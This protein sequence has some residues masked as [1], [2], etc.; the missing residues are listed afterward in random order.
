[1]VHE[2]T[3]GRRM[4]AKDMCEE[5]LVIL[6]NLAAASEDLS[7]STYDKVPVIGQ[8]ETCAC[9]DVHIVCEAGEVFHIISI[10]PIRPRKLRKMVMTCSHGV[11]FAH[12]CLQCEGPREALT[13]RVFDKIRVHH[14]K[15]PIAPPIIRGPDAKL[16]KRRSLKKIAAP[17]PVV[18][19]EKFQ[20]SLSVTRGSKHE[21]VGTL[22]N[23][24]LVR[25]W[26]NGYADGSGHWEFSNPSVDEL[27]GMF[28]GPGFEG[29]RIHQDFNGIRVHQGN[30][31]DHEHDPRNNADDAFKSFMS[32]SDAAWS[33]L[34]VSLAVG[35]VL[36]VEEQKGF[37]QARISRALRDIN[38]GLRDVVA[39]VH[40]AVKEK[41]ED[42]RCKEHNLFNCWECFDFKVAEG[43]ERWRT[44]AREMTS[45]WDFVDRNKE[46]VEK[47]KEL[48]EQGV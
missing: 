21:A 10:S 27:R 18:E 20:S 41:G 26:R 31:K 16:S 8:T 24:G 34:L 12:P 19:Q 1:M 39:F 43:E 6:S 32:M 42:Q 29:T 25:V 15:A 5:C 46:W 17:Q 45:D 28:K 11:S 9:G 40:E 47:W 13:D 37:E 7:S 33:D 14:S 38:A 35:G 4:K 23:E 30:L 36:Q 22:I 2:V 3:E 48:L 44:L